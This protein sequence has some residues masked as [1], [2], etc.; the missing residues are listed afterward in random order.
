MSLVR[1]DCHL[2]TV[3]SGD[4]VT[5]LDE[6]AER[7]AQAGL[8]VVCVTDHNET[9]AAVTAA[10]RN[11][12]VRIIVGEE[13]RT[14][15]GDVIG[16]FLTEPVPYV[17]PV[18]E[19]VARIRAHGGLVYAPHPFDQD[20]SAERSDSTSSS[21][22]AQRCL[23]AWKLPMGRSNWRRTLAY[24]SAMSSARCAPP[25][26][27]AAS[28]TAATSSARSSTA[29]P[30]LGEPISRPITPANSG[31]ASCLVWSSVGSPAQPGRGCLHREQRKTGVG[32][33]DHQDQPG[34]GR[35]YARCSGVACTMMDGPTSHSPMPRVTR[36]TPAR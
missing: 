1:V 21:R 26:C 15:D 8:D 6:L 12:G 18:A 4:A 17:L 36:G 2:H 31:R 29:A 27:S 13:I 34:R 3:A 35:K 9:S 16:L 25:S 14:P 32:G 28:A 11:L 22:S 10:G 24:S 7:A 33:R 19:V 30:S 20:R 23:M 5:T